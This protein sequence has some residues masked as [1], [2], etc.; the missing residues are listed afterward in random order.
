MEPE[1][2]SYASNVALR[3]KYEALTKWEPVSNGEYEFRAIG[4]LTSY[5]GTVR[6]WTCDSVKDEGGTM[7]PI[8]WYK[9]TRMENV[10]GQATPV[11]KTMNCFF[12]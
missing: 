4:A 8:A 10:N 9:K 3:A 5:D 2:Y 12:R 6:N 11:T 1:E 7:T